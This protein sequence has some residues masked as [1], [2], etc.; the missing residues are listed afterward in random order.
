MLVH[1]EPG[2]SL[3]RP[4]YKKKPV[5][6]TSPQNGNGMYRAKSVPSVAMATNNEGTSSDWMML[7]N[8]STSQDNLMSYGNDSE[9]NGN[10]SIM[11]NSSSRHELIMRAESDERINANRYGMV[12]GIM[13]LNLDEND[14]RGRK[15]DEELHQFTE[16]MNLEEKSPV[17]VPKRAD[18][19]ML[20]R[21][22]GECQCCE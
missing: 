18:V 22:D 8:L 12:G 21:L 6:N 9:V 15:R 1:L 16:L 3:S 4:V 2:S 11:S 17:V 19:V 14:G 7:S 20:E 10:G 5:K 13:E